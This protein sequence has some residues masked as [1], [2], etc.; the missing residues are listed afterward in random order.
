M[1]NKNITIAQLTRERLNEAVDVVLEAELDTRQE[2]E[3]H[4]EHIDAHY[5]ALDGDNVVGVIGWYQDNVN[6]ATEAM[7]DKFPGTE[8]Y[9]VGFFAVLKKY[10]GRGVGFT[11][12]KKLDQV[13]RERNVDTLWVASVPQTRVYYERQGFKFFMSGKIRGNPKFFLVKSLQS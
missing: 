9:W 7:G 3:H 6:Y 10:R 1:T 2:I 4:L 5:I 13:L 8:A 11:L 12:I